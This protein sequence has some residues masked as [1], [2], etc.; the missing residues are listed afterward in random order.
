MSFNPRSP[1]GERQS[2]LG[3]WYRGHPVSIHAPR[4]G[5]DCGTWPIWCRLRLSFQSTL[6]VGGATFRSFRPPSTFCVSIHAPRGGSDLSSLGYGIRVILFQSTLPVG[7]ATDARNSDDVYCFVSIHAPRGGSDWRYPSPPRWL[8]CFNPRSPWGERLE[9]WEQVYLSGGFNPRSPWG[10]RPVLLHL[11]GLCYH[12]SI[13]APRGGSDKQ[14][15]WPPARRIVSIHAPRGGSDTIPAPAPSFQGRFNPRSPWGERL[16]VIPGG[17]AAVGFN[18]RSPWGERL[19][20]ADRKH[21]FRWFQS[22]LPVGGATPIPRRGV[23]LLPVSIHAPRGGSDQKQREKKERK[24]VSIHAPRGG[25]DDQGQG[26]GIPPSG[27]NPRSPW[28]ERLDDLIKTILAHIVSIHAPRGG[29][30]L[31]GGFQGVRIPKFQSTLPVGG[32]TRS[33]GCQP[34][35]PTVSI[36]APR[37]GSDIRDRRA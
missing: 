20:D 37:G 7:G 30:D 15:S 29:S 22:T 32:A 17:G 12:V 31:H 5:S 13:H 24:L 23:I 26:H 16:G 11:P 19:S 28:G 18:P 4:G 3:A 33:A 9:H 21:C 14:C 1:W 36:H 35:Y 10:E 6:P 27:F 2:V 8:E 34:V 25:S